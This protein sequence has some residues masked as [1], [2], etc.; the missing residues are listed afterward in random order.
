MDVL[1]GMMTA[2]SLM[3][4]M[5]WEKTFD[6]CMDGLADYMVGS[7]S[8]SRHIELFLFVL[9]FPAWVVYILVKTDDDLKKLPKQYVFA[10]C[11]CFPV[12]TE[13]DEGDESGTE[14]PDHPYAGSASARILVH[15]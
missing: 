7:E 10:A 9:V 14:L 8:D 2:T 5:G 11:P 4:G 12:R 1:K 6:A 3:V 15:P 13:A